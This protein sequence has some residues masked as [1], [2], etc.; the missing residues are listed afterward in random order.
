[1]I[2]QMTPLEAKIRD[3]YLQAGIDSPS[4][5]V[6]YEFAQH[7]EIWIHTY[8]GPSRVLKRN[9]LYSILLNDSISKEEQWE[10]FGHEM[11]HVIKHVG[12]QHVFNQSFKELQEFQANSF[13][14]HFCVPT[15]MLLKDEIKSDSVFHNEIDYISQTFNVTKSFA[16]KRMSHF[17]NQC[18]LAKSDA[19][20]R[21]YMESRH[22]KAGP[23]M[24]E[25]V[26]ALRKLETIIEKRKEK[27]HA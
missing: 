21:A 18:L 23:Y 27:N 1:M 7:Y 15:F 14:Y 24:P 5:T 10:D 9:G 3:I 16:K 8:P 12:N 13:M 11:G 22:P 26:E 4:N 6:M 2:Y 19:E 17:R 20:H 25:T